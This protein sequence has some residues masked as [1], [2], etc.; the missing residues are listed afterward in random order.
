MNRQR[1]SVLW[2][3]VLAALF[4]GSALM[5]MD[6]TKGTYAKP[7][8]KPA[9]SEY[10]IES[11]HTPDEC[12][13][14][15]DAVSAQG[16][17]ALARWNFGCNWGEHVGWALVTAPSEQAALEMVPAAVRDK[18]KVHRVSQFTAEQIRK[19]HEHH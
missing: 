17:K 8:P 3:G 12:L 9:V 13:A 11:P 5:L 18:A 4:V 15:L 1:L 2:V 10:L 16:P 7:I 14:A 6:S 19:F